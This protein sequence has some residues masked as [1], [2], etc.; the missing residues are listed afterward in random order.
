MRGGGGE[1]R[2]H[3]NRGKKKEKRKKNRGGNSVRKA[4]IFVLFPS[5]LSAEGPQSVAVESLGGTGSR[6][7]FLFLYFPACI[8]SPAG[9]SIPAANPSLKSGSSSHRQAAGGRLPAVCAG[10]QSG[11]S[12][13]TERSRAWR[14]SAPSTRSIDL[15]PGPAVMAGFTTPVMINDHFLCLI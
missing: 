3:A 6:L 9:F 12:R 2:A 7:F 15:Q 4:S 1:G 11:S 5:P 13:R 8:R 10:F 14:C